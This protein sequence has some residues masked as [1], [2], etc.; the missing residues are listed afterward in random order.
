MLEDREYIRQAP[1]RPQASA[2]IAL[3]VVNALVYVFQY[4]LLPRIAPAFDFERYFALSLDGL[5]AGHV[6][7]LLTYQ[8]MHGGFWHIFFNCW[9]IY[10]FGRALETTLGKGR[11][12]TLY[13]LS[14]VMGGLVQILCSWLLPEPSMMPEH[15]GAS[16]VV[17]ASAGAFGLV[18]A[19]AVLFPDQRLVMLLFFIIPLVMRARTLLWLLVALAVLGILLPYFGIGIM[20]NIAHAAHL[21]GIITGF[22]F[23]QCVRGFRTPPF[24]GSPTKS[25]LKIT[26]ASD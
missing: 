15:F 5:R 10:V 26:P 16:A 8:F 20:G 12:L 4:Y 19:F 14:G 22:I 9:A 25:S 23:A 11:M 13:F 18:A 24:I 3:I 17:G 1:V 2:T 6:W 21:G 7:Q